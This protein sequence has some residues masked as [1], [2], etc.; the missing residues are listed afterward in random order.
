MTNRQFVDDPNIP[1]QARLFRRV[2]LSQIVP[3]GDGRALISSGA[4]RDKEMSVTLEVVLIDLG[5]QPDECLAQWPLCKLV[6][7][8]ATACRENGQ[9]VAR[10]PTPEEPAHGVV[11]GK[12]TTAIARAL[13][14]SAEWIIPSPGPQYTEIEEERRRR[15]V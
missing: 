12:K 10:D 11:Y 8:R 2:H 6:S 4:F 14:D 13:R 1:D 9:V 5:R 3:G 15:N 7:V